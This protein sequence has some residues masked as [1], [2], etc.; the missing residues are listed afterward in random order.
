MRTFRNAAI[1]MV[2]AAALTMGSVTAVSAQTENNDETVVETTEDKAPSSSFTSSDYNEEYEGD[3]DGYGVDGFGSSKDDSGN[4]V[5][6]WLETW[7]Q[8][9]D[10]LTFTSV[11]GVVVFP[12]VNFLKYNGIIK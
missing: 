1:A 12:I 2:S 3:Q 10:V 7:G 5:P 9:F 4:E 6:R 8:V 11:L